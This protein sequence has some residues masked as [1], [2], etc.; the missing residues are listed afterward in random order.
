MKYYQ[1]YIV[2]CVDNT[3][4][5][6]IA[7]DAQMRERVH[8]DKVGAKYTRGRTPVKL[9][10]ATPHMSKSKALKLEAEVKKLKNQNQKINRLWNWKP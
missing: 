6:G 9:I 1:V 5:T 8:N 2:R 10:V 7:L 4:Y 3:L